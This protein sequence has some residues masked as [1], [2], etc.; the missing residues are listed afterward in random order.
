[1]NQL[2]LKEAYTLGLITPR[3]L[4]AYRLATYFSHY[5]IPHTIYPLGVADYVITQLLKNE[6]VTYFDEL[7]DDQ[8][9]E[10]NYNRLFT[11][12]TNKMYCVGCET[13]YPSTQGFNYYCTVPR[14]S[15]C[16]ERDSLVIP[17]LQ[18]ATGRYNPM[19]ISTDFLHYIKH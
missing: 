13:Y 11:N 19:K 8:R 9:A 3:E 10:Q 7:T 18:D 2:T 4:L 16:H 12:L 14:C 6:D 5:H 17:Y 1:M 15:S